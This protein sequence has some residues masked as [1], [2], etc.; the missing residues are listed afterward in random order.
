MELEDKELRGEF[1][2]QFPSGLPG[3]IEWGVVRTYP[4]PTHTVAPPTVEP[5]REVPVG[6]WLPVVGG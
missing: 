2:L 5:I 1:S 4:P 6:G 3:L